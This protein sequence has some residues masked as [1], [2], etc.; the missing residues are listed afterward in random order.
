MLLKN[1]R[2]D[3]L[4]RSKYLKK[5]W[6]QTFLQICILKEFEVHMLCFLRNVNSHFPN[7]LQEENDW[8]INPDSVLNNSHS[9]TSVQHEC[10]LRY[11]VE[12]VQNSIRYRLIA[13]IKIL[14]FLIEFPFF[15]K[16]R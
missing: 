9:L 16:N 3:N 13:P 1:G 10:L 14:I 5:N 7:R 8:V 6:N 4:P 12:N 11:S 15:S 2:Q